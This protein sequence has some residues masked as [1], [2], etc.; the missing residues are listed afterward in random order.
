MTSKKVKQRGFFKGL[1]L[2]SFATLAA[3]FFGN[4]NN[5]KKVV[6]KLKSYRKK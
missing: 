1:L 3:V 6:G 5:R 2:G 4:K